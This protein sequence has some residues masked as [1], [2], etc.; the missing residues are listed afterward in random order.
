[1]RTVLAMILALS[2]TI[3]PVQG[4]HV[5]ESDNSHAGRAHAQHLTKDPSARESIP[6]ARP[7]FRYRKGGRCHHYHFY[8]HIH[9]D[10]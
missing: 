4:A 9:P 1:M 7:A 8:K 2:T 10:C 3:A 5:G 6:I